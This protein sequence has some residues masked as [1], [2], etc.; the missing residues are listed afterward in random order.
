MVGQSK[1]KSV[2]KH[3]PYGIVLWCADRVRLVSFAAA[4]LLTV[5]L[6]TVNNGRIAGDMPLAAGVANS[7][8][9]PMIS[10]EVTA[11][12]ILRSQRPRVGRV[13]RHDF[14][15]T[16][17]SGLHVDATVSTRALTE[18]R[19]IRADH[20]VELFEKTLTNQMTKTDLLDCFV[21]IARPAVVSGAE[22][23]SDSDLYEIADTCNRLVTALAAR[24]LN[25]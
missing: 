12:R 25:V 13:E 22:R 17:T 3:A 2:V 18:S 14:L 16:F 21:S 23:N 24:Q 1:V 9:W 20:L 5:N 4:H 7:R 19:V 11:G 6:Q 15:L 10:R 8:R